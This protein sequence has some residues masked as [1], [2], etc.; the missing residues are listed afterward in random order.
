MVSSTFNGGL[1]DQF[2]IELG[3]SRLH[4]GSHPQGTDPAKER[5][6][7]DPTDEGEIQAEILPFVTLHHLLALVKA[8]FPIPVGVIDREV[9][10]L[11]IRARLHDT[12]DEEQK[13]PANPK[14]SMNIS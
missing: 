8:L 10:R 4:V 11:R 6:D 13:G 7:D 9:E 12:G 3:A 2:K 14:Y 5:A 1:T